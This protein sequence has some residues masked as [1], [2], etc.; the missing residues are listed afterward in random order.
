MGILSGVFT[1]SIIKET[2]GFI[3]ILTIFAA[4]IGVPLGILGIGWIKGIGLTL[5]SKPVKIKNK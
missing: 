5:L 4:S 1:A 2:S 3:S